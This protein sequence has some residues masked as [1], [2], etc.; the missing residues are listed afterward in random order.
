[1]IRITGI[2][3]QLK[4]HLKG[5]SGFRIRT[6]I[7]S[8]PYHWTDLLNDDQYVVDQEPKG[9][10]DVA[11][12]GYFCPNGEIMSVL[13]VDEQTGAAR[14]LLNG[15]APVLFNKTIKLEEEQ[16]FHDGL[17]RRRVTHP[18]VRVLCDR[19]IFVRNQKKESKTKTWKTFVKPDTTIKY[20]PVVYGDVIERPALE[21]LNQVPD[22]KIFCYIIITPALEQVEVPVG[23]GMPFVPEKLKTKK[24]GQDYRVREVDGGEPVEEVIDMD[25][26]EL[27]MHPV[28]RYGSIVSESFSRAGSERPDG[29]AIQALEPSIP[30]DF[31]GDPDEEPEEDRGGPSRHTRSRDD[32][33]EIGE[34]VAAALKEDREKWRAERKRERAERKKEKEAQYDHE[35]T[36]RWADEQ[37]IMI[38]PT[39]D[40]WFKDMPK[41]MMN[42]RKN[43]RRR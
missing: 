39:F 23:L 12:Q 41:R 11:L 16:T 29:R 13:A 42:L 35:L 8:T 25:E 28:M 32:V 26:G 3:V 37:N 40:V 19:R 6:L 2:H 34:A 31:G 7:M 18:N 9:P 21:G 36:S 4:M 1:M 17:M 30:L 38:Q 15:S 14:A 5:K 22:R 33:N 43:R 24:D 20:P 10:T 27:V